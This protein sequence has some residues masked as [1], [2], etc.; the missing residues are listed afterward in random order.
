VE[1]P[2]GTKFITWTWAILAKNSETGRFLCLPAHIPVPM[3]FAHLLPEVRNHPQLSPS[4]VRVCQVIPRLKAHS[5]RN[6]THYLSPEHPQSL[7]AKKQ[8]PILQVEFY[9]MQQMF[10]M[11]TASLLAN[12]KSTATRIPHALEHLR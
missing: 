4:N 5:A 3:V 12:C 11:G 9:S 1:T 10:K 2:T 6:T 7:R 8:K